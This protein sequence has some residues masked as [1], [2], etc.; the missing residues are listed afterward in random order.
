MPVKPVDV[1]LRPYQLEGINWLRFLNRYGLNGC[2]C[3]DLG[4][5]KTLQTLCALAASH[6]EL[7][8]EKRSLII[9]PSSVVSFFS[10]EE[11]I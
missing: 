1:K 9:T 2:L 6:S 3:D 7:R 8:N 10:A 11:K 5:G 4:L